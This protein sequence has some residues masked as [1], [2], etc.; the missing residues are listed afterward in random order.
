MSF[1]NS[2]RI[3]VS[4]Q[5]DL[6]R[7]H[8]KKA[9]S[10]VVARIA[11][12][13]R[14]YSKDTNVVGGLLTVIR[15]ILR[16]SILAREMNDQKLYPF[17]GLALDLS[18][19]NSHFQHLVVETLYDLVKE[20]PLPCEELNME[21]IKITSKVARLISRFSSRI[22]ILQSCLR[23]LRQAFFKLNSHETTAGQTLERH[24]SQLNLP[25]VARILID[26]L[27][28]SS[29]VRSSP[30]LAWDTLN[31]TSCILVWIA[32]YES[33]A[34]L[35]IP[36]NKGTLL[37]VSFIS[38]RSW[39]LRCRGWMGLFNIHY[40][41]YTL[42]TRLCDPGLTLHLKGYVSLTERI[43]AA[44]R[45][46]PLPPPESHDIISA[47]YH[48]TKAKPLPGGGIFNAYE[49]AMRSIEFELEGPKSAA[50]S[51][52]YP[53]MRI[54][55]FPKLRDDLIVDMEY[56]LLFHQKHSEYDILHLSIFRRRFYELLAS[57]KEA[58]PSSVKDAYTE[59]RIAA[60]EAL[61]RWPKHS[62]FHYNTMK[63]H[64]GPAELDLAWKANH[65]E[66][67]TMHLK[68][69]RTYEMSLNLFN[70]GVTFGALAHDNDQYKAFGQENLML[71][72]DTIRVAY[73]I[74]LAHSAEHHNAVICLGILI[75]IT[76][77]PRKCPSDIEAMIRY[78]R[79]SFEV[80]EA[81]NW[82]YY[83]ELRRVVSDF[84]EHRKE[85]LRVWEPLIAVMERMELSASETASLRS[86]DKS[87]SRSSLAAEFDDTQSPFI[88]TVVEEAPPDK[89][90]STPHDLKRIHKSNAGPEIVRKLR[91]CALE[92]ESRANIRV[93]GGILIAIRTVAKDAILGRDIYDQN[94]YDFVIRCVDIHPEDSDFRDLVIQTLAEF[95]SDD[96][97]FRTEHDFAIKG[98]PK[99]AGLISEYANDELT[100]NTLLMA[101]HSFMTKLGSYK[102]INEQPLPRQ[103]L[104]SLELPRLAKTLVNLL[105]LPNTSLPLQW[106]N[107]ELISEA[108]TW[109]A[110]VF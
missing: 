6:K 82:L 83:K 94:L 33:E 53:N 11:E 90:L 86:P 41:D 89:S 96:H 52:D 87:G 2:R 42:E 76:Q 13:S 29:S 50:E 64:T 15:K 104:Q 99:V 17:I 9:A 21:I 101:L 43:K 80:L 27:E 31:D 65:A 28:S 20:D 66:V 91:T 46:N 107:L 77:N 38:S 35:Q 88:S 67:D 98:I 100:L 68:A 5:D 110:L 70:M 14:E 48:R 73:Q 37:F 10:A 56:A 93:L 18:Q 12:C 54:F 22:K 25:D 74:C 75:L 24:H 59:L 32:Y 102:S 8:K 109:I 3:A 1:L 72:T 39:T 47:R 71:A 40:P 36:S 7:I 84:L 78:I 61:G 58:T 103:S 63:C 85:A 106:D 23:L 81:K 49:A 55:G 105:D 60:I 95:A 4:T 69:Q 108:L 51:F 62:Y 92:N 57:G 26:L 79:A 19:E 45:D 97:T 16:D 34:I 30:P 44:C